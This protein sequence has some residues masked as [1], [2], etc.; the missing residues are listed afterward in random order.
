MKD[1]IDKNKQNQLNEINILKEEL[2]KRLMDLRAQWRKMKSIKR[3][4]ETTEDL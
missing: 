4:A 2:N 1:I 3:P